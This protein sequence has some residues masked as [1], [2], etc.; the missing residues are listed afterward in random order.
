MTIQWVAEDPNGDTLRFTVFIRAEGDTEWVRLAENVEGDTYELDTTQLPDGRFRA[1]VSA[2]DRPS[3]LPQDALEDERASDPFVVDDSKPRILEIE[4]QPARMAAGAARITFRAQDELSI[5]ASAEWR[6]N[7]G[8]WQFLAP[9]DAIFDSLAE[10]FV[11]EIP[12]A[13]F[14]DALSAMLTVRVTD[15]R[16]NTAI[17]QKRVTI[18]AASR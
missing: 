15:E 4:Q 16:G 3:N 11:F 18:Q 7:D 9:E 17:A 8:V 6:L 2:S 10:R 1:R 14:K 5:L 12:R 13:E